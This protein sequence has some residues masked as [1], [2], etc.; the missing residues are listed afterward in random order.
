VIFALQGA[1]WYVVWR[2]RRRAWMLAVAIGWLLSG[3]ALGW[4]LGQGAINLFIAVC[5]FDIWFLMALPGAVLLHTA[6][7]ASP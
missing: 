7:K 4:S 2:L 5:V 3:V 1:C 6:R